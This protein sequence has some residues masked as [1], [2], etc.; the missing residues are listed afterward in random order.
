MSFHG[1][2]ENQRGM[3]LLLVL[4]LLLLGGLLIV[5]LLSFVSTGLKSGLVYE[6]KSNDLFAAD[7]GVQDAIW[8]IKYSYLYSLP[9]SPAYNS[10]D[11]STVWHYNLPQQ[12]NNKGV[13]IALQNLWVPSNISV[14]SQAQAAAIIGAE[15]LIVTGSAN[16]T[17]ATIKIT[18]SPGRAKT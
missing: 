14:P 10:F 9:V 7:A 13:S 11:F 18:Y 5:P 8:Q 16:V 6:K 15:K 17:T 2:A 1:M 3:A 12:V 4:A